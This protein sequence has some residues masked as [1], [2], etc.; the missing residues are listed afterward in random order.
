MVSCWKLRRIN[1][2]KSLRKQQQDWSLATDQHMIIIFHK[3]AETVDGK[4]KHWK[5][6]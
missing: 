5:I 2:E 3:E 4:K 1:G 6:L